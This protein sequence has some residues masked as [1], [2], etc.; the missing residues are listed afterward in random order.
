MLRQENAAVAFDAEFHV[1]YIVDNS[2]VYLSRFDID[3]V[4]DTGGTLR[5]R[6]KFKQYDPVSITSNR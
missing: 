4:K 2:D 5:F 6:L 1:F 3:P